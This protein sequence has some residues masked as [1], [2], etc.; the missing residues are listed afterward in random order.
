MLGKPIQLVES[1]L[2][3]NQFSIFGCLNEKTLEITTRIFIY[4]FPEISGVFIEK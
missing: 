4:D 2:A 1:I 3:R